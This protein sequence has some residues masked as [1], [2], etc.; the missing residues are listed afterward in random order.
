MFLRLSLSLSVPCSPHD[1]QSHSQ[2]SETTS[3]SLVLSPYRHWNGTQTE[4]HSHSLLQVQDH[5]E[6]PQT[7]VAS[8]LSSFI[9]I[10]GSLI[11]L[12][13]RMRLYNARA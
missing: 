10:L 5:K 9:L 13:K 2:A 4:W 1:T 7:K 3:L 6:Q 12:N 11:M 8:S